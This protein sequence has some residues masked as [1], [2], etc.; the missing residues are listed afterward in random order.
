MLYFLLSLYIPPLHLS[1]LYVNALLS[2]LFSLCSTCPHVRALLSPQ[3]PMYVTSSRSFSLVHAHLSSHLPMFM[4]SSLSVSPC[5]WPSP[6]HSCLYT[7][8]PLT[9]AVYVHALLSFPFSLYMP[10]PSPQ[11]HIYI[12]SS[13]SFSL[14]TCPPHHSFICT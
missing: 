4:P 10:P 11:L 6:H 3:L 13:L 1:F 8:P 12:T 14:C 7:C 9:T 2:F 5:T